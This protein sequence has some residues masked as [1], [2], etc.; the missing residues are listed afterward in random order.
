MFLKRFSFPYKERECYFYI[1]KS[2]HFIDGQY[3]VYSKNDKI[4]LSFIGINYA[5]VEPLIT[6]LTPSQYL[7]INF[8]EDCLQESESI[9]LTMEDEKEIEVQTLS[10]IQL[11]LNMSKLQLC[12]FLEDDWFM[13][14]S[15]HIDKDIIDYVRNILPNFDIQPELFPNP[16]GTIQLEWEKYYSRNTEDSFYLEIEIAT[17]NILHLY[18]IVHDEEKEWHEEW[19]EDRIREVYEEVEKYWKD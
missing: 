4:Y 9:E 5:F 2:R 8:L 12:Q 17:N 1:K 14:G 16:N 15:Y 11:N 18:L 3:K 13:K 19:D 6:F 7:V 10:E